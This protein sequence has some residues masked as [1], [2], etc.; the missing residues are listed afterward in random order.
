MT[1]P[2]SAPAAAEQADPQSPVFFL[3]YAHPT[4]GRPLG[5][6][7][8]PRRRFI[9]FFD[10]LSESVAE[11][12]GRPTGA[13]PGFMDRSIPSGNPW[14]EHLLDAIGTSQ[15]CV[16]LLSVPYVISRW[17][18]MEWFAFSRRTVVRRLDDRPVRRPPI[19]PVVWAPLPDDRIPVKAAQSFT[20]T[21]VPRADIAG[22]YEAE[23]VVGLMH[24]KSD[25]YDTVV[26]RLAQEISAFHYTYWVEPHVLDQGELRDA[27]REGTS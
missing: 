7:P 20:L 24:L 8:E 11:L 3:S 19:I 16:A 15:I 6:A 9:S 2:A 25:A 13:D 18:G 10:D 1:S 27:F 26:W 5:S 12:V 4:G 21:G 14:N 17:C 23:G 22:Q